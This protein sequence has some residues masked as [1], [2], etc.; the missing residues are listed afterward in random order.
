MLAP[1]PVI[2]NG[3]TYLV[4]PMNPIQILDFVHGYQEAKEKGIGIGAFGR[5]AL[6]QCI[7]ADGRQLSEERNFTSCFESYPE[8][9]FPLESE[10]LDALI[11]PFF[12]KQESI[13]RSEIASLKK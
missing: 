10:A 6:S 12:Q 2:V 5:R 13:T 7:D 11:S 8:D 1:K 4:N 3:R 9:M